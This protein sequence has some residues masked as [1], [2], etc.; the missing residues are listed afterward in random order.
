MIC[1]DLSKLKSLTLALIILPLLVS[2]FSLSSSSS[3]S[4]SKEIYGIPGSS[5]TSPEW[6]WG[7]PEGAAQ[8]CIKICREKY[9]TPKARSELIDCLLLPEEAVRSKNNNDDAK[10]S[11]RVPEN[12]EEVKLVLALFWQKT[13]ELSCAGFEP[14][15]ALLDELASG[16][17]YEEGTEEFCSTLFTQHMQKRFTWLD[18]EV[19]EKLSMNMLQYSGETDFDWMRRRCSGLVLKTMDFEEIGL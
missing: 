9:S 5:W 8:D 6:K 15:W 14:Y 2:S 13:R 12:F 16:G 17:M 10:D 11:S 3:S 18:P 4:G 19:E 7:S 1:N